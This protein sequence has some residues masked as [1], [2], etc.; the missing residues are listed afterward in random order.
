MEAASADLEFGELLQ[1]G[2]RLDAV[3]RVRVDLTQYAV[4][5]RSHQHSI[6]R[7]REVDV[8]R[9]EDE[10]VLE[11]RGQRLDGRRLVGRSDACRDRDRDRDGGIGVIRRPVA[12]SVPPA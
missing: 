6:R 10:H 9:A 4:D 1:P 12:R 2:D 5:T 11:Q 7:R 3:G 8:R